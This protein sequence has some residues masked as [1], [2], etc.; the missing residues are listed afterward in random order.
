MRYAFAL[1]MLFIFFQVN[2]QDIKKL[3]EKNGFKTIKFGMNVDSLKKKTP[4]LLVESHPKTK[5]YYYSVSSLEFK[6]VGNAFIDKVYICSYNNK[7]YAIMLETKGFGNSRAILDVFESAYGAGYK[8]NKYI[9]SYLWSSPNI[10]LSY[11]ENSTNRNADIM[12]LSKSI[13]QLRVDFEKELANNAKG[14]L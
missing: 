11:D 2:S 9:E 12:I 4:M 13:D 8:D 14:D 10:L 1:V 3:D 7:V 5:T 6:K